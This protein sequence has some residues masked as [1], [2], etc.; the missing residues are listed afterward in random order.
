MY[1]IVV[2]NFCN[3]INKVLLWGARGSHLHLELGSICVCMGRGGGYRTR[4][5]QSDQPGYRSQPRHTQL[6]VRG[7]RHLT[8]LSCFLTPSMANNG[9]GFAGQHMQKA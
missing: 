6:R 2:E 7:Q 4:A 1:R 9:D 5:L 8:A 3:S